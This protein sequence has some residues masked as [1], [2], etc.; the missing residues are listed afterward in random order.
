MVM[1]SRRNQFQFLFFVLLFV[2]MFGGL[3]S[4]A[5]TAVLDPPTL[6][7]PPNGTI[8]QNPNEA[9]EIPLQWTAVTGATSYRVNYRSSSDQFPK[10][11]TTPETRT[12]LTFSVEDLQGTTIIQWA[13]QSLADGFPPSAPPTAFSFTI[14][15]TG[16]PLPDFLPTPTPLPAPQLIDPA[17]GAALDA[18]QAINFRWSALE[19]ASSYEY[20]IYLDNQIRLPGGTVLNEVSLVLA[21]VPFVQKTY[22]WRVRALDDEGRTGYWSNRNWFLIDRQGSVPFPTPTP[23][24][25]SLDLNNDGEVNAGDLFLFAT[26]YQTND[27]SVDFNHNGKNDAG[28]LLFFVRFLPQQEPPLIPLGSS[29]KP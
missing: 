29:L 27:P 16:T 12:I 1:L 20:Q 8:L 9:F 7:S 2:F 21:G 23:S 3:T 4:N 10:F 17:N 22:Q 14:G 6:V 18:S 15:T 28:D 11:I 24:A 19:E 5:Q 26:R 25:L 13:V